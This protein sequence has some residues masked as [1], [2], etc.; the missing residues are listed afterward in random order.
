MP[1]RASQQSARDG[2]APANYAAG[3]D[4]LASHL[5]G[6][7]AALGALGPPAPGSIRVVA[8][9]GPVL[10]T[11][12]D[13]IWRPAPTVA[14]ALALPPGATHSTG[15]VWV[16]D[17]AGGAA[18]YPLTITPDGAETIEGEASFVIDSNYAGVTLVFDGTSTWYLK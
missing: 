4:T 17:G 8:A 18:A 3:G 16:K 15:R 7:D 1:Q 13:V 14:G 6:I 9:S 12:L 11:D 2:A 5:E 10:V